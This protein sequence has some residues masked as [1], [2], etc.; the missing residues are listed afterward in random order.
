MRLNARFLDEC[1]QSQCQVVFLGD[2]PKIPERS[3]TLFWLKVVNDCLLQIIDGIYQILLPADPPS[4]LKIAKA[5]IDEDEHDVDERDR[6]L[7]EIIVVA[8]D[9]LADLVDERSE[10]DSAEE[11]RQQ[12]GPVT[13]ERKADEQRRRHQQTS[14]KHVG[15]VESRAAK[16]W[17]AGDSEN[18]PDC[19]HGRHSANDE[20]IEIP[21]GDKIAG[22]N[23]P[24]GRH[25][26]PR[27]DV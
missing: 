25:L 12:S 16:A 9:E 11:C 27:P 22:K 5:E 6:R 20:Q 7:I 8:R 15:D 10:S 26:S 18:E 23:G 13:K 24:L 17:I 3:V 2:G 21:R 14:P 4:H 19:Q 1:R